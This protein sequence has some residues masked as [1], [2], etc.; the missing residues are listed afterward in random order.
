MKKKVLTAAI[1]CAIVF[2]FF[3]PFSVSAEVVGPDASPPDGNTTA[4]AL[5]LT[6]YR[7]ATIATEVHVG[8][9]ITWK[10]TLSIP[11]LGPGEIGFNFSGGTLVLKVDG[12]AYQHVA[13]FGDVPVTTI[14]TVSLGAPFTV[15][16]PF[17]YIV[18]AA[19][20]VE[21]D[22]HMYLLAW[23][24]YGS[25]ASY[26]E[27]IK[28]TFM[29][30][31]PQQTASATASIQLHI[32]E[33][34]ITVTK[35][36]D[37]PISKVGD[38]VIYTITVENTGDE[39]L[40]DI[41]VVDSLLGDLGGSYA[42]IMAPGASET[43]QFPYVIKDT[44][45]DP[46]PNVV[47]VTGT[48][49]SGFTVTDSDNV[50]VDLVHPGLTLD[51][52]TSDTISKTGDSVTFCLTLHNTGDI[53]LNKVSIVSDLIGPVPGFNAV[54][55]AGASENHCYNYI[56]KAGDPDPLTDSVVVHYAITGLPNDINA[57]GTSSE[58]DLVHPQIDVVKQANKTTASIGETVEFT[59][60]VT[61]L[62]DVAL[63]LNSFTDTLKGDIAAHFA[64]PLGI[65][66][67]QQ[68]SY[69]FVITT[70][71]VTNTATAHYSIT[72]LPNDI[73]DSDFVT[74]RAQPV[75]GTIM[76]ES[77]L[78]ILLPWLGI[79]GIIVVLGSAIFMRRRIHS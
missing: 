71:P 63:N 77:P 21:I 28:G 15:E 37:T 74:V 57:S 24:E 65:G 51:L 38:T 26:P 59:V 68:W 55:P 47:E 42:D 1:I 8:D 45:P 64:S 76:P 11:T 46:L 70:L 23:A 3:L 16:T 58:I 29:S 40:Y 35:T 30:D 60:K 27:G 18:D 54:L 67:T 48:D 20:L 22:G 75:G 25:T 19:D 36:A 13:G 5:S 62:G 61:N 14:P 56:V 78:M 9:E 53:A 33:P 32:L 39:T 50:N 31:P 79:S 12:H 2:S 52:T 49:I 6:A 43:H 44:D 41:T 66:E 4:V 17:S 73:T 34:E 72:G 10:M 69:N 7:G